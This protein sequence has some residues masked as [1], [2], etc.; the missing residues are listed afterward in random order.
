MNASYVWNFGFGAVPSTALGPGPHT[1]FYNN[2]TNP[3]T[4]AILTV[5]N[6]NGTGNQSMTKTV[7][8]NPLP[9]A[10]LSLANNANGFS[11]LTQGGNTIFRNCNSSGILGFTFN[12][13]ESNG[14]QQ[15]FTWGDGVQSSNVNMIGNQVSHNYPVGQFNLTH[16]VTQNGCSS[17]STY[18]VFN[19]SAPQV[20]VS[21][22][23]VNTCLP[24]S[25]S[26]NILSNDV[27]IT[28]TVSF[29]DGTPN[30]AFTTAN[31][32]TIDHIFTTSSCGV[33]YVIAPGL[34]PIPNAFSSTL[35]AQNFCSFNGI[36]TVVIVGPI[37]I[38]EPTSA[39]LSSNLISPI[40]EQENIRFYNQSAA[41][42]LNSQIG[43]DSTY[44]H[45]W[46]IFPNTYNVINGN[47]GSDNGFFGANYDYLQWSSG[48][49]SIDIQFTQT[50]TYN[51]WI[52][53]GDFCGADSALM[54]I[55]VNNV[56][57]N[58]SLNEFAVGSY[59]LNGITYTQSGTYTQIIPASNGCDSI[60]TLILTLSNN[61]LNEEAIS[62]ERLLLKI[63]DING[64]EISRRKNT[65]MFLVFSDGTVERILEIDE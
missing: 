13:S 12:S 63:M 30:L 54:Q 10:S 9:N 64:R 24:S 16:T 62:S 44:A 22:S 8:A 61:G 17:A 2:V 58:I 48:T 36:Q 43:C 47:L 19:G 6:N 11:S 65:I 40:C 18:I 41:G 51:I 29:T 14:I 1:V 46:S 23:G 59:T 56:N 45:F 50:G 55:E 57:S 35:T 38:S 49:D 15:L 60:I 52:K 42:V 33:D 32:T 20:T 21:G 26:I 34:P 39:D 31:D 3:S 25:Y 37:T 53:T 7:I 27:P 5:N 28:Y 4:S